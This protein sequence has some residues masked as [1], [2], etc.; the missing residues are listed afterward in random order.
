MSV[1][2]S[3][4]AFIK[5][6]ITCGWLTGVINT[7]RSKT[8]WGIENVSYK[9]NKVMGSSKWNIV[10]K[11]KASDVQFMRSTPQNKRRER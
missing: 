2:S 4:I 8:M 10:E 9:I 1:V 7:K 5:K 11:E 6:N 3:Q